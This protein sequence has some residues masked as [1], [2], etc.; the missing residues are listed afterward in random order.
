MR[1]SNAATG[2]DGLPPALVNL[3]GFRELARSR[4]E[5]KLFDYIDGGAGDELTCAR[6]RHDLDAIRFAPLAFRDVTKV[7]IGWNGRM[8]DFALPIGLSPSALHQLVCEQG[9]LATAAA[10]RDARVPM[11]VS[12]MS[13]FAMEDIAATSKHGALWLQT[14]VLKDR[15]L[16]R[17][18]VARA[19]QSGFKALVVSA[20]CPVLGRRDRNIANQFVLPHTI[21]AGNFRKGPT[22][23]PNHPI[24]S[25][26]AAQPDPGA[27]WHD[28]ESLVSATSLPVIVK[29]VVNPDDVEAALG[30]GVAGLVV[31]NHGGRQL[32]GTISAIA[33]LPAVARAVCGR[34]PLLVD[35]GFRRGIDVVKA[36]ALGAD[37]VLLGRAVMWALAADGERGVGQ[38][39]AM[40]GAEFENA[41]QL[42]GCA[43]VTELREKANS[44]L[45]QA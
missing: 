14:Y 33:A 20:G 3:D 25:F 32:D 23:D 19:E 26:P 30:A 2:P 7:D 44:V 27:T 9:E 18:M 22:V 45:I 29:G 13:S 15:Q 36:I 21:S 37:A 8:G 6:N 17:D 35:G 28:L 39:L 43:S 12:M 16:G 34:V 31:S 41:M 4:L 38:A 10:A 42:L 24:H 1:D 11:I 40:L 5:P